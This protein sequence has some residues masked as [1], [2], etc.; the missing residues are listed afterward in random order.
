[1]HGPL[2]SRLL[3]SAQS[4]DDISRFLREGLADEESRQ[5]RDSL[6]ALSQ[7]IE[8]AVRMRRRRSDP[9]AILHSVE[10]LAACARE[11]Q[12]FLTSLGSAW[13]AMY[14]L[15]VYQGTL[16]ELRDA[17]AAWQGA[18]ERRSSAERARFDSFE[19]VAWR[20]VGEALLLLEMYEHGAQ[21]QGAPLSRAAPPAARRGNASWIGRLR[22][23]WRRSP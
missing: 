11:H 20:A 12:R 3:H 9:P 10:Q 23:W 6:V 22:A 18:L 5:L 2:T 17:I 8:T 19:L 1:M 13:H 14:E 21:T 7:H 16:R 15:G 4:F